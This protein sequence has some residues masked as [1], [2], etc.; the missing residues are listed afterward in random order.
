VAPKLFPSFENV[1]PK[2]K[3]RPTLGDKGV[4][5][6]GGKSGFDGK[7]LGKGG[8]RSQEDVQP[9]AKARPTL[10]GKGVVGGGGKSGFGG[11]RLGKGGL[12]R[13]GYVDN[14]TDQENVR[15]NLPQRA[16]GGKVS[17]NLVEGPQLHCR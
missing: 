16:H 13:L 1:Q 4:V 7:R 2:P 12:R 15:Q 8:L 17:A 5:G 9:K 14:D 10:G 11:K 6:E 3:G